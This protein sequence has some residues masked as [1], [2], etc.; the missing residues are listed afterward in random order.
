MGFVSVIKM[1]V[2]KRSFMKNKGLD[3]VDTAFGKLLKAYGIGEQD[4]L[5]DNQ[6]Y[7]EV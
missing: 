3:E 2:A 1:S 4:F 7:G 5:L 6:R